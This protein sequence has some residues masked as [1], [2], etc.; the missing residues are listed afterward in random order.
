M[1]DTLEWVQD[2]SLPETW[3]L[4]ETRDGNTADTRVV[5]DFPDQSGVIFFAYYESA[6]MSMLPMPEDM[7]IDQLK[8]WAM[9]QFLL[10]RES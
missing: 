2:Q 5:F 9:N 10:M 1:A 6:K 3:R 4:R 8:D 7:S